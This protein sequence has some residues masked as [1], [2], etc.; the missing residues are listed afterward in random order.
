MAK[1]DIAVFIATEGDADP[2][3]VREVDAILREA[4]VDEDDA[5][6]ELC[7]APS[8]CCAGDC[9]DYYEMLADEYLADERER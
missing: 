8:T 3:L 5:R 7:G 2:G 4:L 9:P 6:C 1:N